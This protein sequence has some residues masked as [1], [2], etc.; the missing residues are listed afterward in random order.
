MSDCFFIIFLILFVK[1][2]VI[3]PLF[4]RFRALVLKYIW[5]E[6]A[7]ISGWF[8]SE[9][10]NVL[11]PWGR[12]NVSGLLNYGAVGLLIVVSRC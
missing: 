3:L 8:K 12:V 9:E 11:Y 10:E 2:P 6:L 5:I 4:S 7:A 1:S